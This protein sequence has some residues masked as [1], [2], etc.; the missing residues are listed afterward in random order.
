M[1]RDVL[2]AFDQTWLSQTL[3]NLDFSG[4]SNKRSLN[5][6]SPA[7]TPAALPTPNRATTIAANAAPFTPR[8][9]SSG[10]KPKP[11]DLAWRMTY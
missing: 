11:F 3:A 5:V 2:V 10:T 1:E 4:S 7:F 8:G 9:L 6:E